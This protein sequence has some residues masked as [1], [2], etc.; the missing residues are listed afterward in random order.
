MFA[1]FLHESMDPFHQTVTSFPTV[2]YTFLLIICL[3]YWVVAVL[4]MV[5]LDIL[6][7]D[8]DGDV[9]AADSA[10]A[11]TGIAGLLLKFGLGGVPLTITLT[12]ISLIGWILCYYASYFASQIIPT[13]LLNLIAGIGIF[14]L[15]SYLSILATAQVIKPIRKLFARLDI[16]ETKHIIG[17]SVVVRSSVVNQ[18]RG[19]AYMNDGG[20]GILLNVRATGDEEFYKGDEVVVIEKLNNTNLYRVIAKSE[21]NGE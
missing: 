8:Y 2:I 21:F 15:A 14:F 20:A 16:D 17:Q 18:D 3:L 7:L 12:I 5:D 19:E 9:D 4:G 10:E 13:K 1:I 6:D 11:Q